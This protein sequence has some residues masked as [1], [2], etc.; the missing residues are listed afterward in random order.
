MHAFNKACQQAG[1]HEKQMPAQ[2]AGNI[3]LDGLEAK[4]NPEY[5]LPEEEL[6]KKYKDVGN[7]EL[8]KKLTAA[9]SVSRNAQVCARLTQSGQ[10]VEE[11][12]AEYM[13]EVERRKASKQW[14]AQVGLLTVDGQSGMPVSAA[15]LIFV[16]NVRLLLSRAVQAIQPITLHLPNMR[17]CQTLG[18]LTFYPCLYS[19][20]VPA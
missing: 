13:Q 4:I 20:L 18:V 16:G 9:Q 11:K 5:R 12:A 14:L 19:M 7:E 8:Q 15:C 2:K 3:T 17:E 1:G 6:K 10:S